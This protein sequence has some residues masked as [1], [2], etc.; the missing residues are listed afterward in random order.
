MWWS[1]RRK[2]LTLTGAAALTTACDFTPVYGPDGTGTALRG[3]VVVAEPVDR[4]TYLLV[5]ELEQRFGQPVSPEYDLSLALL[6]DTE[7]QAVT[8]TGDITRFSLVGEAEF[9]LT[10]RASG[11]S[12]AK[13]VV[14]NFTG[15]SATGSTV[16][17]LA[18]ERDAQKR[19]M[20]ILADQIVAQI[21]ATADLPS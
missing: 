19:L 8:P 11:A 15:Y 1:D 14:R 10:H 9:L 12:A 16:E 18:S 2:F 6:T 17:T 13:G 21:H 20:I 5:Q 4:D 3:R 7:G